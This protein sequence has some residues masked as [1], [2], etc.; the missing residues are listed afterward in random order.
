MSQIVRYHILSSVFAAKCEEDGDDETATLLRAQGKL[1]LATMDAAELSEL[2]DCLASK[3]HPAA[4]LFDDLV[5]TNR[6]L[7]KPPFD[8]LQ[9]ITPKP[10][11]T[12]SVN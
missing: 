11:P 12:W 10:K 2:A 9:D 7:Q 8:W 6:K 3:E 4:Q 1:R 5:I